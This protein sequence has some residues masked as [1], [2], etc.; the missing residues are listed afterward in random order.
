MNNFMIKD[1]KYND[2]ELYKYIGELLNK[3]SWYEEH[4][5]YLSLKETKIFYILFVNDVFVGMCSIDKNLICDCHILKKYRNN[6]YMCYLIN[7]ISK[8][9]MTCGTSNIFMK[10]VLL[11]NNFVYY[12]SRGKY[13]YYRKNK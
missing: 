5:Q 4:Y 3:E 1:F 11:K 9:N 2:K 6:G 7:K 13:D 10:K 8:F 12:L